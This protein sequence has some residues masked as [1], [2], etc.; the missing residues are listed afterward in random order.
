VS[1]EYAPKVD[2]QLWTQ[3]LAQSVA[4][5]VRHF[6]QSELKGCPVVVFD[7]GCFPWHGSIELSFLTAAE[8]DADPHLFDRS[9]I[10]SWTHYNFVGVK[11][12]WPAG[13][14]LGQL[15]ADLYHDTDDED[16][17]DI[18]GTVVEM[19]L[20]ASAA[21]V[22]TPEGTA[23]LGELTRDPRFQIWVQHPDT[24]QEFWPIA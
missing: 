6:H 5:A 2:T 14:E 1:T 3:R 24:G 16:E 13:K 4:A 11:E 8:V 15:M 20:R 12:P 19:F 10:A 22:A 21:A 18:R 7:L 9:A 23:A 17:R